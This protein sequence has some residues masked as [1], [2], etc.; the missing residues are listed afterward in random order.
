MKNMVHPNL[1]VYSSTYILVDSSRNSI[2]IISHAFLSKL[3][4]F[5]SCKGLFTITLSINIMQIMSKHK[6]N[7]F[8][9]LSNH[10]YLHDGLPATAASN[11]LASSNCY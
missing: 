7:G 8:L 6:T 3:L 1:L 11:W 2:S 5:V 10:L 4:A 9:F